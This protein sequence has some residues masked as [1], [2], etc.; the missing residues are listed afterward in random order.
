MI[1]QVPWVPQGHGRPLGVLPPGWAPKGGRHA[2]SPKPKAV[3]RACQPLGQRK[4]QEP[5]E[6]RKAPVCLSV[7]L[8][9]LVGPSAGILSPLPITSGLSWS[10]GNGPRP[11]PGGMKA[12]LT[13]EGEKQVREF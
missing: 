11:Q 10:Q 1:T 4:G 13:W 3:L 12:S 2:L 9:V 6:E 5:K 7:C 8:H